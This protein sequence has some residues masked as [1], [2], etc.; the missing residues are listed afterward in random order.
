MDSVAAAEGATCSGLRSLSFRRPPRRQSPRSS[1]RNPPISLGTAAAALTLSTHSRHTGPRVGTRMQSGPAL[2]R[3][4]TRQIAIVLVACDRSP[5][6]IAACATMSWQIATH[7]S[8]M[9]ADGPA[10]SCRTALCGVLQ[11]EQRCSRSRL[12][13]KNNNE[14]SR[15]THITRSRFRPRLSNS[16]FRALQLVLSGSCHRPWRRD[17][18]SSRLRRRSIYA[19]P[20]TVIQA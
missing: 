15:F 8:Q 1:G 13:K 20:V 19:C 14:S 9:N 7:S 2:P 3:L 17:G 12:L 16:V 11:N 5:G 4:H 6:V 10:M 18:L